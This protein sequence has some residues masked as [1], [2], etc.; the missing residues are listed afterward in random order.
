MGMNIF[1][2]L[3]QVTHSEDYGF[4]TPIPSIGRVT[5]RDNIKN[6]PKSKIFASCPDNSNLIEFAESTTKQVIICSAENDFKKEKYWIQRNKNSDGF[7]TLIASFDARGVPYY[8][9]GA[10]T[11]AIYIDGVKPSR[12]NAYLYQ[13]SKGEAL[14]YHY[15][16]YYC[17]GRSYDICSRP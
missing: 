9:R 11:Y 7:F 4:T 10:T 3:A 15:S 1:P 13:N 16:I 14:L 2:A 6:L 12:L 17:T 5:I 8:K